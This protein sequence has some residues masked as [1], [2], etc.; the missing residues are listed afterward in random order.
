MPVKPLQ[1]LPVPGMFA[2]AGQALLPMHIQTELTHPQ[3]TPE[4]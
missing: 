2:A 4:G 3:L 1:A